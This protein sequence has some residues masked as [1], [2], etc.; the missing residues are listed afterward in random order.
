[1]QILVSFAFSLISMTV[2]AHFQVRLGMRV[3]AGMEKTRLQI[4]YAPIRIASRP[5]RC[6]QIAN[7]DQRQYNQRYHQRHARQGEKAQ[8]R[9]LQNKP[10]INYKYSARQIPLAAAKRCRHADSVKQACFVT[11]NFVATATKL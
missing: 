11:L 1:V 5:A 4:M 8:F 10:A 6:R 7:Q 9:A 3:L 2:Q